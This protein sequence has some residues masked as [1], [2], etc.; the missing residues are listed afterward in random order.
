MLELS[1]KVYVSIDVLRADGTGEIKKL[2]IMLP[3]EDELFDFN[4]NRNL[5]K[6][7]SRAI[8][9]E[10]YKLLINDEVKF[11]YMLKYDHP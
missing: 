3:S 5:I 10:I 2:G 11:Q 6:H 1:G 8:E 9:H 7:F 4:H